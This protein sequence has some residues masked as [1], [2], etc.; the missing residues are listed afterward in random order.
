[1]FREWRERLAKCLVGRS[2]LVENTEKSSSWAR[3]LTRSVRRCTHPTRTACITH[4]IMLR[5]GI[6]SPISKKPGR[7]NEDERRTPSIQTCQSLYRFEVSSWNKRFHI[8]ASINCWFL[9]CLGMEKFSRKTGCRRQLFKLNSWLDWYAQFALSS[10]HRVQN[11][12]GR[13]RKLHRLLGF[14]AEFRCVFIS[15]CYQEDSLLSSIMAFSSV[16][17]KI[18]RACSAHFLKPQSNTWFSRNSR[19]DFPFLPEQ[20]SG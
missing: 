18:G 8:D 12:D 7:V 3:S 16:E 5:V 17:N 6:G 1:V 2:G 13:C 14:R 11:W 9:D 19:S 20:D 4:R 15:A 10:V